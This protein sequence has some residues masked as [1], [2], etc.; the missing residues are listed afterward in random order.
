METTTWVQIDLAQVKRIDC[1]RVYPA[2][3]PGDEHPN[4]YGFPMRFKI[5]V[6][7]DSSCANSAPIADWTGKDFPEPYDDI[8]EFGGGGTQARY[9][10]LTATRLRKS[11]DGVGYQLAI[12]KIDV[13]SDGVDVAERCA[14][15]SDD[16]YGNTKDL[17]Q[18]TR[19][20]RPMGEGV[21]TDHPENISTG[22]KRVPD[23][24]HA[25]TG[26]V[27]LSDGVF[28]KAM[29]DNVD[30]L[31]T[32][33]SVDELL[34]PFRERAGKPIRPGMRKPIKFWDTSL[35]GSNAGRF[36]MGAGNTLRWIEHA[37]LRANLNA[38][39]DGI[40]E[41][42][43]PNGY[44][45]A[46]PEDL[47]LHSERGN[48]TRSWVTHG[49]IEA[50]YAG[51]EK[52]FPLLRGFYDWFNQCRWLPQI[53]RGATQGGQ[54]M[55]ASTRMF[56]TPLGKPEDIHTIQRF[57]QEN[58][59]LEKLA[60]RDTDFVWQYPYDRPHNYLITDFEAYLDMY[61][62]TGDER[63]LAA[64]KGAWD[65]YHDHWEHV[66]GSI[67][68]TEFGEFP[69]GSYR[70]NAQFPF[71]ETGE[72][73]GSV[74][75]TRFNQ[76]FQMIAPDEEKY[77]NEIEKSIYN[78]GLANQVMSSGVIYHARLVGMKGDLPVP[79]CTNSCCEGQGTRLLGSL[80][81]YIYSVAEDGI[82]VNLFEPSTFAWTHQTTAV[83]IE[84]KGNFPMSPEVGLEITAS[85]PAKL[86]IRIR[87]PRWAA[88]KMEIAVNGTA[89]SSGDPGSYVAI[90]R[91]WSTGDRIQFRLPMELKLTRYT[92]IDKIEGHER[93]ALEY[94]PILMALVGEDDAML[95]LTAA[96]KAEDILARIKEDPLR[97]LHFSIEGHPNLSYIPYWQVLTERF[98]CFPVIELA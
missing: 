66:G 89:A 4:G 53:L 41:C 70:L 2:F 42:R 35:P 94:G 11:Q 90:D 58:Y 87:V 81:E 27:Q 31:L 67:A 63:Y 61:R 48:Y 14:V 24:A 68:I 72:T 9:V 56:F 64:M 21:I 85:S 39:V 95:K 33:F 20:A 75:W 77:A 3:T 29:A 98:T 88:G 82:Y 38:V 5:E 86:R 55:V 18:I 60:A 13:I 76:R 52:A 23:L 26:G 96:Q 62:A 65:L 91:T 12:G 83:K 22:W 6:S 1:V 92:G 73:C 84:L 7:D 50:G 28:R 32:S 43:E 10:R 47:I 45:M 78:V 97:P 17:A 25:P 37:E 46:Y 80:P 74:F 93:Y 49:L 51:N 30:Y 16:A 15:A 36:M 8:T 40:A 71:C 69:P 44:I 34:R 54:G 19:P 79:L 59:W 57:Y